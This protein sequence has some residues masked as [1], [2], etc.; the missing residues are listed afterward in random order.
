M[1][2]CARSLIK[3]SLVDL[4]TTQYW[5][6]TSGGVRDSSRALALVEG[7]RMLRKEPILR[8]DPSASLRLDGLIL[9]GD[10]VLTSV[11]FEPV[12]SSLGVTFSFPL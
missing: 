10:W 8:S 3:Y 12:S 4:V 2:W 7:D 9:S 6:S 5:W 1:G 11:Q